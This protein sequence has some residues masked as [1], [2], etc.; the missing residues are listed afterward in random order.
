MNLVLGQEP[1]L[2][3]IMNVVISGLNGEMMMKVSKKKWLKKS[4]N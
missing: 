1:S 2:D 3:P 4:G